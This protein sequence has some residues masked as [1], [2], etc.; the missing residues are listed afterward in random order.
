MAVEELE[1]L[2]DLWEEGALTDEEFKRLKQKSVE[3]VS[4]RKTLATGP[5]ILDNRLG[6]GLLS[7]SVVALSADPLAMPEVFLYKFSETRKTIY[8]ST[9]R[10]ADFVRQDVQASPF[11]PQ[12]LEFVDIYSHHY[13]DDHGEFK[14]GSGYEDRQTLEFVMDRLKRIRADEEEVNII[15]DCFS[16]FEE[17]D[18][19]RKQVHT[20]LNYVYEVSRDVNGLTYLLNTSSTTWF[21]EML[22]S[23]CD[24]VMKAEIVDREDDIAKRLYVPKI[25]G[26]SP[27]ERSIKYEVEADSGIRV[28]TSRLV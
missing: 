25:R 15:F 12:E 13:L 6:G 19:S 8:F 27:P 2:A 9:E 10:R 26:G 20:L 18:I 28:D 21:N 17:L 1:R 3:T 24:A 14:M 16:F 23:D 5:H 22:E 4:E 11:N 7:G